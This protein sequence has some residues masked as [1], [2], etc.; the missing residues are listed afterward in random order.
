MEYK[1]IWEQ[2]VIIG[3][4]EGLVTK[5]VL[6]DWNCHATTD[7]TKIVFRYLEI[8]C[9]SGERYYVYEDEKGYQVFEKN[10]MSNRFT[11]YHEFWTTDEKAVEDR[12][13]LQLTYF[14]RHTEESYRLTP[15]TEARQMLQ[16]Y[17]LLPPRVTVLGQYDT[18]YKEH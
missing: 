2:E 14:I 9:E 3:Y 18:E 6:A 11:S 8:F 4:R 1:D 15:L 7:N 17:T 10:F 16:Q 13:A 12:G 5:E